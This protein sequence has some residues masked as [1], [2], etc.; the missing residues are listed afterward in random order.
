MVMPTGT[1]H[2]QEGEASTPDCWGLVIEGEIPSP[3]DCRE[4]APTSCA[5]VL[6]AADLPP[7]V[8][9]ESF[10]WGDEADGETQNGEGHWYPTTLDEGDFFS[11][12][13]MVTFFEG[14]LWTVG[15]DSQRVGF[16]NL[17]MIVDPSFSLE[18]NCDGAP[19]GALEFISRFESQGKTWYYEAVRVPNE[20]GEL[21]IVDVS[22][23]SDSCPVPTSVSLG[24]A[25]AEAG[26]TFNPVLLVLVLVLALLTLI[27]TMGWQ[28]KTLVIAARR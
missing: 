24:Q 4:T 21:V 25:S 27:T 12:S 5:P 16:Y 2:A 15:S 23:R 14:C 11:S 10:V 7:L 17:D 1:A 9:P 26:S 20:A 19:T 6:E 13:V 28:G 8:F 3:D 18:G 22:L